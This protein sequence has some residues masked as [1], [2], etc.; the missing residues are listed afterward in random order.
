MNQ[1][2]TTTEPS[3]MREL[4][5]IEHVLDAL[6]CGRLAVLDRAGKIIFANAAVVQPDGAQCKGRGRPK[7]ARVVCVAGG[8]GGD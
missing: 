8:S 6:N 1:T 5:H 2:S 3:D 7:C 4:K